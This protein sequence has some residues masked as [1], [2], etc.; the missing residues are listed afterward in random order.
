MM[1]R[2]IT[3]S[4]LALLM[5][6][7]GC[8]SNK[9]SAAVDDSGDSLPVYDS[10]DL[11]P[12]WESQAQLATGTGSRFPDFSLQDQSGA[13]LTRSDLRG[14]I[15]VANFFFTGCTNLCPKLRSA[16]G[17]VRAAFPDDDNLLLLSHSITPE[18]DSVAMLAAYARTNHIDGRQWHLLTGPR[19]V[20]ENLE[21]NGYLI[22]KPHSDQGTA[23]HTELFVLL[24]G[25]QRVRG[26]YNATLQTE[27]Q[28]LIQDIRKLRQ[29][30]PA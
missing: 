18:I 2:A 13:R 4:A 25:H 5:T 28:F 3:A 8:K 10:A 1:I 15:V 7:S 14:H 16:M 17:Q 23:L 26:V 29:S 24:D 12:H 6:A 19:E 11:T 21:F 9:I 27:I 22:P 30:G 20:I